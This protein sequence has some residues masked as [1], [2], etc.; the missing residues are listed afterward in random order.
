LTSSPPFE[1]VNWVTSRTAIAT[2]SETVQRSGR[3]PSA[4]YSAGSW[5]G[6][7]LTSS[8]RWLMPSM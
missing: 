5:L 6:S 4:G 8:M 2:E 3:A 7:A 1:T